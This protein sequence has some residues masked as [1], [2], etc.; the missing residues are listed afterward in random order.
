MAALGGGGG[1]KATEG[2]KSV[3]FLVGCG[4][5]DFA[6]DGARG[7]HAALVKAGVK[8]AVFRGYPDVEHLT[9]VQRALPEVFRFFERAGR[10]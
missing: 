6:L 9:V 3:A 7:L 1:F 5:R 4:E 2:V 8:E 10:R